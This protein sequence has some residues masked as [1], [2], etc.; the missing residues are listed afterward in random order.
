M[1]DFCLAPAGPTDTP[2]IRQLAQRIWRAHYPDIIGTAQTEYM[3]GK[4]YSEDGLRQ[5]MAEG[6]QF[7]LVQDSATATE[8]EPFGFLAVSD[9]GAGQFF[10]H[11]FYLDNGQRG[12]GLGKLVFDLLLNRCT[13]LRELRLTV[14]RQNFKSINFYFKVGF[15]I[16]QCLDLPIGEGYEMNDF[17]MRFKI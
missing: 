7:W 13:G 10:L 1:P 17:L 5:Q 15:V 8:C 2:A 4:F 14:N 3:L 11:K 16:E 12:L 6:Q 9:K